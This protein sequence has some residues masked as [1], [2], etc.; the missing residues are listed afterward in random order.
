MTREDKHCYFVSLSFEEKKILILDAAYVSPSTFFLAYS[1][2]S[3]NH[4]RD[5]YPL[6]DS[7]RSLTPQSLDMQRR[8]RKREGE[9]QGILKFILSRN[10]GNRYELVKD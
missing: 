4:I 2:K 10:V 7:I 6:R 8:K 1:L 3:L 5:L 9:K